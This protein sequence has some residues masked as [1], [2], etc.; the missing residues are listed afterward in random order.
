MFVVHIFIIYCSTL[1]Y[2]ATLLIY[3]YW[4]T[5]DHEFGFSAEIEY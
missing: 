3:L 2:V 4:N 5:D 1:L